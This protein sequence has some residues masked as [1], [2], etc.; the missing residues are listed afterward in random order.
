VGA[1]ARLT[2]RLPQGSQ[3]PALPPAEHA[4]PGRPPSG[5]SSPAPP[6][7]APPAPCQRA[8]QTRP[9]R[10]RP[11]H[12][13]APGAT[14]LEGRPAQAQAQSWT[15]QGAAAGRWPARS[16]T[17]RRAAR[18]ARGALA[19]QRR[20]SRQA[21]HARRARAAWGPTQPLPPLPPPRAHVLEAGHCPA[22][23]GQVPQR[24]EAQNE[25]HKH[26]AGGGR[27]GWR[28]WIPHPH[29]G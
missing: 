21:P 12:R 13:W 6:P 17:R 25:G 20:R 2:A 9:G 7:P 8:C 4:S 27:A 29:C 23:F 11:R 5:P 16:R 28:V 3:A 18:P 26:L 15:C 1:A 24:E 10:A 22:D 19:R 14:G